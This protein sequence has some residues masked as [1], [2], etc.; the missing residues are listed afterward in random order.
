MLLT[1]TVQY[2][3][4]AVGGLMVP[5]RSLGDTTVSGSAGVYGA[6]TVMSARAAVTVG[7][8]ARLTL[9]VTRAGDCV[10]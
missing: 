9:A 6:V 3:T 7:L 2:G 10:A 4:K 5:V 8:V 1:S